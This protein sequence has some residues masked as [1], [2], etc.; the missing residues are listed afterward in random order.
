MVKV[1]FFF[2]EA[3]RMIKKIN[4]IQLALFILILLA[5]LNHKELFSIFMWGMTPVRFFL[6]LFILTGI[7]VFVKN[8][9]LKDSILI[10]L[11]LFSLLI[12]LS[13]LVAANKLDALLF[14]FFYFSLPA[15]YIIYKKILTINKNFIENFLN[16]YLLSFAI[17]T[18]FLI[19]QIIYYTL[20]QKLIGAVWPV[21]GHFPRF[22]ALFW[23]INHF[24]A[25]AVIN[26]WILI[27]KIQS[28]FKNKKAVFGYSVFLVLSLVALNLTSSRSSIMGLAIGA[29][30][31]I[32]IL[33]TNSKGDS[34]NVFSKISVFVFSL[35]PFLVFLS[36]IAIGKYVRNFFFY[37]IHSFFTHFILIKIGFGL[38]KEHP[39]LGI[40][41][42]NF[43]GALKSSTFFKDFSL[44]DPGALNYKIPIHSVW[45]HFLTEGGVFTFLLFLVLVSFSL[46]LLLKSY[47]LNKRFLDLILF[48]SL[49]SLLFAGIFYSYNLEFYWAFVTFIFFYSFSTVNFKFSQFKLFIFN[50]FSLKSLS[51]VTLVV[52]FIY[53]ISNIGLSPT[54]N[55][56]NFFNLAKT[57]S[58]ST[59]LTKIS[60]FITK[61][62]QYMFGYFPYVAR[63][64]PLTFLVA[65]VGTLNYVI[66]F[67]NKFLGF[68][69]S[70]TL[71][72]ILFALSKSFELSINSF[73]IYTAVLLF[74]VLKII[75]SK[76]TIKSFIPKSDLALLVLSAICFL[77]VY[78]GYKNIAVNSYNP[79]VSKITN[80][81]AQKYSLNNFKIYT[82]KPEFI[83]PI[84]FY[85]EPTAVI[86]NGLPELNE[87]SIYITNQKVDFK[88]DRVLSN[89]AISAFLNFNKVDVP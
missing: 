33:I 61:Q 17:S 11:L 50:L 89:Q 43:D 69:F 81:L 86:K 65:S 87:D 62:Y 56:I 5:P 41:A 53:L 12:G 25:F 76:L 70:L 40:G 30:C 88:Y 36:S 15:F 24:G 51:A 57:I 6:A 16:T 1:K 35:L 52:T 60:Y 83:D 37:R 9:K 27:Y 18:A 34:K 32:Y 13:T 63:L 79:N 29:L 47:N 78:I 68:N 54:L 75:F 59:D 58:F 31:L 39:W 67:K 7:L 55:E 28:N 19:F 80:S 10:I 72:T 44:L 45:M 21:P 74:A 84:S 66:K 48:C 2:L 71:I 22:G 46:Y 73:Y 20:S 3:V 14:S 85:T 49:V 64:T 42:N 8:P 23:D 26:I 77:S 4:Y 38:F 82:F